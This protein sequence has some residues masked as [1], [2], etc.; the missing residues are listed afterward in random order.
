[1]KPL[2]SIITPVYNSETYLKD[3]LESILS[4]DFQNLE[5]IL[6]NDGSKDNSS[7]ICTIYAQK[8][9]RI[10]YINK[11]N[12]GVATT[13]NKG[14][15]IA[16]G[17]YI[18]F[19]D[20]DDIIFPNSLKKIGDILANNQPDFLRY[21][22]ITIDKN[23]QNLYPNYLAHKRAKYANKILSADSFMKHIMIDE[24]FLCMNIF[25]TSIIN[26]HSI[27]FKDGCTYNEDTLF[28][29]Q[30]MQYS[31]IHLY[32][33]T[34]LY[35]YRKYND[36][37]TAKFTSKNYNDVLGVFN[38]LIQLSKIS[39]PS[40]AKNMQFTIQKIGWRLYTEA[41]RL[42]DLKAKKEIKSHCIKSPIIIEW[43]LICY[44]GDKITRKVYPLIVICRKSY[45][46]IH[47]SIWK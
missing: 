39:L 44:L 30:F 10:K 40:I 6:L 24:Y 23:G 41:N 37:V 42:N 22:F 17:E 7:K 14:L 45:R 4:Q 21:D 11:Q 1:M 20:S 8:D 16:T 28:I 19:V 32:T 18:M 43:K 13:R 25:K 5:L 29:L 3:T 9:N 27:R 35:G 26:Q 47:H 36:A 38:D 31:K 33:S 34:L 15:Q 12:E 46:K 2:I